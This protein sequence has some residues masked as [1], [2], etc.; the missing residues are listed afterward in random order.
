M[1]RH[2]TR[3]SHRS[4]ALVTCTLAACLAGCGGGGDGTGA[5]L[6]DSTATADAANAVLMASDAGDSADT[7]IL[8]AQNVVAAAAVGGLSSDAERATALAVPAAAKTQACAGGGT[9]TVSITGGTP[10]SQLNGKLDGGEVYNVVFAACKGALG[11]GALDGALSMT[12]LAASGDASNGSLSVTF[13]ATQL[14]LTTAR[15]NATLDGTYQG[16]TGAPMTFDFKG[17]KVTVTIATE[18]KV[19]SY[20]VEGDKITVINPTDG[21]IVLMR[22]ADGS[23]N[24]EVG[25][26]SKKKP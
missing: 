26:F 15:G 4:A 25:V 6:D 2:L 11:A 20:K 23:L 19:L 10:A 5:S 22:N 8:T 18:R 9:A 3:M 12:V 16:P 14:K 7:A 21:D 13:T 1:H 24:S 17:D